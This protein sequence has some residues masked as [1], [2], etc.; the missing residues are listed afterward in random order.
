[1]RPTIADVDADIVTRRNLPTELTTEFVVVADS[2]KHGRRSWARSLVRL[3]GR[4]QLDRADRDA[5]LGMLLGVGGS[6][7]DE[8]PKHLVLG[9]GRLGGRNSHA[10]RLP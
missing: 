6:R 7:N 10:G 8:P 3:R 9:A 5:E 2:R 4:V 1:M